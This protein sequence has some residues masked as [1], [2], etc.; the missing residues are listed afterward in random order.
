MSDV[1][2]PP[3]L[4]FP[5]T[6]FSEQMAAMRCRRGLSVRRL[7]RQA[8]L[9]HDAVG[10]W[11][12]GERLP[13]LPELEA[14]LTALGVEPAERLRL[15]ALLPVQRAQRHVRKAMETGGWAQSLGPIP[16]GGT[17]LR[18]MR[19][20][21]GLTQADAARSAGVSQGR[22]ARWERSEDWPTVERLHRLCFALGAFPQE[23]AALTRGHGALPE[24]GAEE[25]AEAWSLRGAASTG[26]PLGLRIRHLYFH[27]ATLRDLYFLSLERSLR[28]RARDNEAFR[29]HLHDAYTYRSRGLMEEGRYSEVGPYTDSTWELARQG[30]GRSQYWTWSVIAA[31]VA[32]R[33]G[34]A[35]HRPRPDAAA[36]LLAPVI[37][38][39][40]SVENQAWMLSELALALTEAGRPEE[41]L[42]ASVQ[43]LAMAARAVESE[44][45][46]FRRRD[47][48]VLLV[49]LKQYGEALEMLEST[50][51]LSCFGSDPIIRHHLLSAACRL[52]LGNMN[53]AHENLTPALTLIEQHGTLGRAQLKLQADALLARL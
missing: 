49:S 32:L 4:S 1:L 36:A 6:A 12:R 19:G 28:L 39:K 18:A 34:Y 17:L 16:G 11:E 5:P 35:G 53:A 10:A 51:E 21:R 30:Y 2:V 24:W 31:A 50:S 29:F 23:V 46:L 43:A 41:A 38:E 52:G 42:R 9:S 26:D 13:R 44:E 47:H 8:G 22:R 15:I 20:R 37:Q 7:A 25:E 45:L 48:A 27:A 14:A 33:R 3:G 40:S